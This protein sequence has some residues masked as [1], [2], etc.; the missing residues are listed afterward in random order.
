MA[1]IIGPSLLLLLFISK[2]KP[3]E[4][5]GTGTRNVF[6]PSPMPPIPSLRK[7]VQQPNFA[8]RSQCHRRQPSTDISHTS[9]QIGNEGPYRIGTITCTGPGAFLARGKF[10]LSRDIHVLRCD[11]GKTTSKMRRFRANY[12]EVSFT[13]YWQRHNR[14]S[15]IA[16]SGTCYQNWGEMVFCMIKSVV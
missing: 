12:L 10:V 6:Y 3:S 15:F 13:L 14:E 1:V 2:R 5:T 11:K 4:S 7:D 9:W 16:P 8:F